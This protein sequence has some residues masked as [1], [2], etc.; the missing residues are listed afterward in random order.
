MASRKQH[1]NKEIE[2]AVQYAENNGWRYKKVG[3]SAHAWGRML[4]PAQTR[5]GCSISIWST[6][7]NPTNHARQIRRSVDA[8]LH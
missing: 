6:P 5:D 8:C 7:R 3:K 2:E 1:P 4:C